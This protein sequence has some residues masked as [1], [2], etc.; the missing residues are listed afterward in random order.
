MSYTINSGIKIFD[1]IEAVWKNPK[2][3]EE[4]CKILKEKGLTTGVEAVSKYIRTLRKSGFEI[5]S[6]KTKPYEIIKTPFKITLSKEELKGFNTFLNTADALFQGKISKE[7]DFLKYKFQNLIENFDENIKKHK[8]NYYNKFVVENFYLLNRALFKK[9]TW[10]K[11][12][13]LHRKTTILPKRIKYKQ[14]GIFISFYNADKMKV[15]NSRADIIKNFKEDES[16]HFEYYEATVFKLTGPLRKNYILREGEVAHYRKDGIYVSNSYEE[17]NELFLRLMRYG[18]NCEI[19]S[20][21]SHKKLFVS[22]LK[23]LIEH[24]MSM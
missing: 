17:K 4:L 2:S 5:K 10:F 18:T 14:N 19:I 6:K 15:Q 20:P 16:L 8:R 11:I 24:Y 7:S 23:N 3:R 13:N 22:K 9:K 12:T 1:F 21:L